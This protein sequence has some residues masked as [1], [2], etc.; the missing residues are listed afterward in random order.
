MFA[1]TDYIGLQL[2][3]ID[4]VAPLAEM[5]LRRAGTYH[6]QHDLVLD[7]L[8]PRLRLWIAMPQITRRIALHVEATY[9][10]KTSLAL[11]AGIEFVF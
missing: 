10:V 8:R 3:A 9:T 2:A 4:P 11:D 1:L 5:A 7:A 6:A